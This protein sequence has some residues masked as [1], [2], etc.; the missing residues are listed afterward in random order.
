MKMKKMLAA[1]LT[2]SMLSVLALT[3][4]GSDKGTDQ[5]A[6]SSDAETVKG[7]VFDADG[8]EVAVDTDVTAVVD[9]LGEPDSYFEEPSC[10]GQ[11]LTKIYT[12]AGFQIY[13]YEKDK[14]DLIERIVLMDDTVATPEGVDLSMTR[15]DVIDAYGDDHTGTD[16][17]IVY[18]KENMKLS[19]VFDG[20]AVI[21]IEYVS[22]NVA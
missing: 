7:Y 5:P 20:E 21:S 8:V 14:T 11:G 17:T 1:V 19:F 4:C 18:E 9:K 15:D 16:N 3:G 10:A 6:V 12:Y 13:T 2:V 22:N